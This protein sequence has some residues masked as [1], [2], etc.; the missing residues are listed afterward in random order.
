[1]RRDPDGLRVVILGLG[2][3]GRLVAR[4]LV[5]CDWVQIAGVV[6]IAP[7]L[8]DKDLG[9]LLDRSQ[10]L[11]VRVT[12]DADALLDRVSPDIVVAATTSG[13]LHTIYPEIIGALERGIDVVTPCMDVSNPFLYDEAVSARI[14]KACLDNGATFFGIG[15]TQLVVRSLLAVAE[16]CRQIR[17]IRCFVHADVS[18]FPLASKQQEFGILLTATEYEEAV[19]SGRI[20]GRQALR[21]E[22]LLLARSLGLAYDGEASR[23]EPIIES[24]R[25]VGVDHIFSVTRGE[26]VIVDYVYRF[27]EDSEHRYF[28]E[29]E[30]ESIPEVKAH[31]DFSIDRGIEGTAVPIVKCLPVVAAA[32]PGILSMLDLPPGLNGNAGVSETSL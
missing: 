15:S 25:V 21:K 8:V 24:E 16:T 18:K 12:S 20:K 1:M 6:D 29:Y 14:E 27:I 3:V 11:E 13:S 9:A 19:A 23:Y 17:K 10:P 7:D 28:H 30:I 26:Q 4:L 5:D 22:A 2:G 32:P 31:V